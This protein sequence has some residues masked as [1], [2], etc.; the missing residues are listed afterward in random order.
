MYCSENIIVYVITEVVTK[1][2]FNCYFVYLTVI[3]QN[4]I[5]GLIMLFI[6]K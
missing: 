6:D 1:H 5:L 4:F 3:S 2:N